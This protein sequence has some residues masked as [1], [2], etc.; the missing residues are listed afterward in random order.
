MGAVESVGSLGGH[1]GVLDRPVAV[2]PVAVRAFQRSVGVERDRH[3][4]LPLDALGDVH[5]RPGRY[6]VRYLPADVALLLVVRLHDEGAVRREQ[7]ENGKNADGSVGG[8]SPFRRR[9]GSRS[10]GRGYLSEGR[11]DPVPEAATEQS[12][13]DGRRDVPQKRCPGDVHREQVAGVVAAR[14]GERHRDGCRP[15]HEQ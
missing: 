11:P 3:D 7:E 9:N 5:G 8:Q 12:V 2:D 4:G 6:L 13:R 15:P 10:G 1:D 14:D